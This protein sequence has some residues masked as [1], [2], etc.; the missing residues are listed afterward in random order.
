MESNLGKMQI[1]SMN[2]FWYYL[3]KYFRNYIEEMKKHEYE[4]PV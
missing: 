3:Y 2:D 4:I 1:G